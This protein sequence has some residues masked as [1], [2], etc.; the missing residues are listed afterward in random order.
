MNSTLKIARDPFTQLMSI[1]AFLKKDDC[2]QVP[3][4]FAMI[5]CHRKKDYKKV[6]KAVKEVL[7]RETSFTNIVLDFK[8]EAWTALPEVF[9]DVVLQGLRLPLDSSCLQISSWDRHLLYHHTRNSPK[10]TSTSR[11]CF[12]G[13]EIREAFNQLVSGDLFTPLK[14]LTDNIQSTWMGDRVWSPEAW[15]IYKGAIRTK[16]DTG[17]WHRCINSRVGGH[18]LPFYRLINMLHA[19]SSLLDVQVRLLDERR[20]KR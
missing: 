20:L 13:D 2:K 3:L 15:S 12:P 11:S 6:L 8:Q 10:T 16:N 19:K 5:N 4:A 1:H 7:L 18:A 9:P 14:K 17:G